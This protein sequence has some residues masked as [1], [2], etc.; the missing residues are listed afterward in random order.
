MATPRINGHVEKTS[1]MG[2]SKCNC[3][4]YGFHIDLGFVDFLNNVA[5]ETSNGISTVYILFDKYFFLLVV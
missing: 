1:T 2:T 5:N 4:P 3:C